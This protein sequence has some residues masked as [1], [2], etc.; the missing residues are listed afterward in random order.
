MSGRR[1]AAKRGRKG[2]SDSG[3][4]AAKVESSSGGEEEDEE[5]VEQSD[6]EVRA[7]PKGKRIVQVRSARRALMSLTT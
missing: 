3:S 2:D 1:T 5:N 6:D 4:K 7:R